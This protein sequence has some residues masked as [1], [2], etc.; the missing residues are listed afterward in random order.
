M[1]EIID[2]LKP[3]NGGSFKLIEDI[4]I[5]VDGYSS[6]ADCVSHMAT[7]AM[8]EAINAVLSGKQDKLTTAQLTAVNSGI[9]SE[10]VAQ[11]ST[12][13]AAIAGKADESDLAALEAV[14][15]TKADISTTESLQAQIDLIVTPVTQDAEVQNARIDAVM[16]LVSHLDI[17]GKNASDVQ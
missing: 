10:L 13:T 5:A 2:L 12:N 3:K 4:D 1:I 8:I 15:E 9:T 6:L 16:F 14:V 17:S 11:I 7:T